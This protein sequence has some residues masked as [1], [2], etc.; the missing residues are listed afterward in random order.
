[1]TKVRVPMTDLIIQVPGKARETLERQAKE[2]GVK[3]SQWAGQVFDLGFAAI[4]AREKSTPVTDRDLDAI[5]GATL[6]LWS[7]QWNTADIACAMGVSEQTIVSIL[8]G[9]KSYRRAA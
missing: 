7:K 5:C 3:A 6:L 9:W 2:R 1:M 4:C 8:D